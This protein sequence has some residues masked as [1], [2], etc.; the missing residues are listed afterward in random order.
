[1]IAD[2]LFGVD[3][4]TVNEDNNMRGKL[5]ILMG[6]ICVDFSLFIWL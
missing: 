1:M 2:F 5:F 3:K 4:I 6:F